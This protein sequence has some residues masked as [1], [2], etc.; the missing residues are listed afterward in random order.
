[1]TKNRHFS[2]GYPFQKIEMASGRNENAGPHLPGQRAHRSLPPWPRGGQDGDRAEL[3]VDHASASKFEFKTKPKNLLRLLKKSTGVAKDLHFV[4]PFSIRHFCNFEISSRERIL[5]SFK[6][7]IVPFFVT[8]Q[9][10]MSPS[11]NSG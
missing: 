2:Q 5:R 1:M 11:S 6:V 7:G 3:P 10:E 4:V 8:G 9:L